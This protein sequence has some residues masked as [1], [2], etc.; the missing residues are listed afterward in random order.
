M[1]NVPVDMVYS[2]FNNE[3]LQNG[4][5]NRNSERSSSSLYLVARLQLTCE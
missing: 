1:V 5:V 3:M 2:P 4:V